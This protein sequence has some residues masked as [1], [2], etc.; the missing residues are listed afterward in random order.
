[1]IVNLIIF[2]FFRLSGFIFRMNLFIYLRLV[3]IILVFITL[4]N[5]SEYFGLDI[6]F[7]YD[8]V[9]ISL[10]ILSIWVRL[11]IIYSRYK[12]I[13]FMEFRKYFLFFVFI[14]LLVLIIS[15]FC[16]G[17]LYFYFFF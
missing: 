17:F 9:R 16:G 11:L 8:G 12:I 15:F 2:I 14:L 4:F 7:Y 3:L 1:M 6:L 13:R 5:Y 10:V